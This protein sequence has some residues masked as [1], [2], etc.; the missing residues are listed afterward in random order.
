MLP[1]RIQPNLKR[2][3][4]ERILERFGGARRLAP[5][6]GRD[7]A[8]VYKWT[9]PRSAGGTDGLIPTKSYD[10]VLKAARAEGIYLTPADLDPNPRE[11]E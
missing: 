5:L 7:P 2:T 4:A 9:Y 10:K 3:Q 6:I 1:Q 8:T 11:T